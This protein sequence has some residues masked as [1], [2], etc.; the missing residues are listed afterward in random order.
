MLEL[1]K[2]FET[3]QAFVNNEQ[4]FVSCNACFSVRFDFVAQT[5]LKSSSDRQYLNVSSKTKLQRVFVTAHYF[6]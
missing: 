2:F 4:L 1:H 3:R 5:H 6:W